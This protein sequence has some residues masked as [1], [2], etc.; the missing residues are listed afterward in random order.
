[1]IATSVFLDA[2]FAIGTFLDTELA[3]LTFKVIFIFPLFTRV[4]RVAL[5]AFKT[6]YF[7]TNL[8]VDF[9]VF[10]YFFAIE[11]ILTVFAAKVFI[12]VGLKV[13]A[14]FNITDLLELLLRH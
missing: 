13:F 10:F 4:V 14:D 2:C 12:G 6:L 11:D 5:P 7:P 3:Q 1:M 9:S 8:T